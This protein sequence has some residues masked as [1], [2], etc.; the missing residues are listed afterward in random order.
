MKIQIPISPINKSPLEG[1]HATS[2]DNNGCTAK[3]NAKKNDCI[4][5]RER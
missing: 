1:I 2:E 4:L 3:I 5:L